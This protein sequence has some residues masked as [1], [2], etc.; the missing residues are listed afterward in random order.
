M[1]IKQDE[2]KICWLGIILTVVCFSFLVIQQLTSVQCS[3]NNK[4]EMKSDLF[5]QMIFMSCR[6]LASAASAPS[7]RCPKARPLSAAP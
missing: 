4:P 1:F 2:L 5:S 3:F 6:R 7:P